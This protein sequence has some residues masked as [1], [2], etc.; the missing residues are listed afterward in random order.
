MGKV[1]AL[2]MIEPKKV[3][4][5]RKGPNP[6]QI[7]YVG[8]I[9]PNS[10]YFNGHFPENP[11]LPGVAMIDASVLSL[12]DHLS[13]ELYLNR[14]QSA[15]FMDLVRPGDEV[16]LDLIEREAGTWMVSWWPAQNG[17]AGSGA[18]ATKKIAEFIFEI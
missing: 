14:I 5:F 1:D 9:D 15:K 12:S 2:T 16:R 3:F 11:V 17:R 8:R 10:P 13:K 7:S 6:N 18:I 4:S